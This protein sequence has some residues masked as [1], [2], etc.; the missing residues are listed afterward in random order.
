VKRRRIASL[1]HSEEQ[2][3]QADEEKNV[4]EASRLERSEY[5]DQ[6][7]GQHNERSFQKH[8][9]SASALPIAFG[10]RETVAELRRETL[11]D[12]ASS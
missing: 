3:H 9:A 12:T 5:E 2:H 7:R 4:D 1:E 11:P 8:I 6:P 10:F